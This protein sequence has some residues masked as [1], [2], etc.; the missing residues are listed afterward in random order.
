M[1][2]LDT[3]YLVSYYN[4]LDVNH[5]SALEAGNRMNRGEWG[6]LLVPEYVFAELMSVLT[7]RRG[8]QKAISVG[9]SLLEGE[10]VEIVP[11]ISH[12][13]DAFTIFGNQRRKILSFVDAAIVAIARNLGAGHVAT[14]DGAFRGIEGIEVVP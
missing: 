10:D 13:I 2:V 3:S 14:F 1:I 6:K 7:S 11:C 5:S 9:E 8:L 12:M 4:S